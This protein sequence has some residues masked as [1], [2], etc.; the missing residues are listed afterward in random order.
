MDGGHGAPSALVRRARR[1]S[2][3][4]LHVVDLPQGQGDT[5]GEEVGKARREPSQLKTYLVAVERDGAVPGPAPA[6]RCR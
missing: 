6:N 1:Q 4:G 2:E 3:V 5:S